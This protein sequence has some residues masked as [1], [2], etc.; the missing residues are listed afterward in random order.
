MGLE[1]ISIV[2]VRPLYAGN[3]GAAARALKNMALE[4]L[5]LVAP[6]AAL[7]EEARRM[8]AGAGDLLE[9]AEIYRSLEEAIV[10][11]NYVIGTTARRGLLRGLALPPRDFARKIISLS[12]RN[13]ISILFGPEDRGLSNREIALCQQLIT[14]PANPRF[15]SLN[16]AQAVLLVCY[17]LYL[18]AA[19]PAAPSLRLASLRQ[20]EPMYQHLKEA[21]LEIGFLDPNN[22]E[23]IMYAIRRF[24]GRAGLEERDVRI[25]RGIS[26][27][28]KWL[29][30]TCGKGRK[31]Q[32]PGV[33][34][35]N[36]IS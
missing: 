6:A 2:L 28:I 5:V 21:L 20:L 13:E 1:N 10:D 9:R 22:P 29:A 36:R 31:R 32:E 25:I 30:Q 8:A 3:I 15:N 18:A 23:R 27:Q 16:L 26:R 7:D 4:R 12:E 33:G 11:S 19:E 14:I 34:S 24:L 17:E 35:Q